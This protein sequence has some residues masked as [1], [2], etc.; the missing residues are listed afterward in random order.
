M[1]LEHNAARSKMK[2]V[3]YAQSLCG[4]PTSTNRAVQIVAAVWPVVHFLCLYNKK[5]VHHLRCVQIT[6]DLIALALYD[7][8]LYCDDSGSMSFEEGVSH[9]L[10]GSFP[11]SA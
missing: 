8:V 11:T 3:Y 2:L 4:S 10:A 6:V 1:S 7:V 9:P 5:N